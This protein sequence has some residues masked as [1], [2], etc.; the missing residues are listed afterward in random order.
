MVTEV[1]VGIAVG[2]TT[3]NDNSDISAHR[4]DHLIKT[5]P[6]INATEAERPFYERSRMVLHVTRRLLLQLLASVLSSHVRFQ[7][8]DSSYQ[9][10]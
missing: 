3:T 5:P 2:E 7:I 8:F 1:I 4:H 6:L 10:N 9:F